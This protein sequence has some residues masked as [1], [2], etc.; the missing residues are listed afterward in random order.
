MMSIARFF[1][2]KLYWVLAIVFCVFMP[3][4]TVTTYYAQ[5]QG[6][7][8]RAGRVLSA[9]ELRLAVLT[10]L[11]T[12]E[13][14][15]HFAYNLEEGGDYFWAGINSPAQETNIQ[16]IINT[17]FNNGKSFEEN[18][19]LRAILKGRKKESY[20]SHDM[21]E[22]F[23][24]AVYSPLTRGSV[25]V[26]LSSDVQKIDSAKLGTG[27]QANK[28]LEITAYKRLLG[29]GNHYFNIPF[30]IFGRECCDNRDQDDEGYM[31]RKQ[32]AY[33]L[34]TATFKSMATI[35]G[36][37]QNPSA[38]VSNCGDILRT[39]G[40]DILWLGSNFKDEDIP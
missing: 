26:Y 34:V 32:Q 30:L 22:P 12:N 13:I 23:L 29:Y 19:G 6:M 10:D 36:Y 25:T 24:L 7:C 40:G 38:I 5:T 4:M 17:S 18:F 27:S 14:E 16:K 21:A 31:E 33:D 9:D 1:R 11:A 2:H 15:D 28:P 8:L 35:E 20:T 39:K 3:M 37:F